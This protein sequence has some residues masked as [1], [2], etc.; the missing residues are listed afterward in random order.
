MNNLFLKSDFFRTLAKAFLFFPRADRFRIIALIVIQ[1][2]LNIL[3]LIGVAIVGIFA[4]I[5]L[6]GI[7]GLPAA[8]NIEQIFTFINLESLS[9]QMKATIIALFAGLLFL[10]KT[11]LSLY[12]SRRT[13]LF[14]S[15]KNAEAAT[16]I[17]SKLLNQDLNDFQKRTQQENI[18]YIGSGINMITTG[19][20]STTISILADISSLLFMLFGLLFL[21]PVV[22]VVTL[23]MFG[24]I[25]LSLYF[26]M[27]KSAFI[28]GKNQTDL[29]IQINQKTIEVFNSYREAFVR[30]RRRF[31]VNE[32]KKLRMLAAKDRAR[33]DFLPG[34]SRY[35]IEFTL[36][37]SIITVAGILFIS[38]D[39]GGAVA[40]LSVFAAASMRISPA[41]L[42]LQQSAVSI[43]S[44]IGSSAGILDLL[45][46]LHNI[47]PLEDEET[48]F[49]EEHSDFFPRVSIENIKFKYSSESDFEIITRSLHFGPNEIVVLAGKSG[50]GK[51][52]FADL[53]LGLM[54]VNSGKVLISNENPEVALKRW[55]GAIAYVPQEIMIS[56]GSI[57]ENVALGFP[58]RMSFD[59]EIWQALDSAQLIDFV[60]SLKNGL[61]EQIGDSGGK[62]S[63]G[64][65]QRLGIARALFTKPKLIVLDEPTSA[66]DRD[67][68][69]SFHEVLKK[70]KKNSTIILIAHTASSIE[71]ADQVIHFDNGRVEKRN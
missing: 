46:D 3:D 20:I 51:S 4:S 21:Q 2:F 36:V 70:L 45:N 71:I 41:V 9:I 30:N 34:L 61:D 1:V 49:V 33:L 44:T 57:R 40:G 58:E 10:I 39:A 62:L 66:L 53:I 37:L 68:T 24:S 56:N 52:T 38:R 13:I 48:V 29:S 63:G 35:V 31:Y 23:F 8:S 28:L 19:V 26:Y 14:L 12:L 27:R 15:N 67:T 43:R 50:S 32:I 22:A 18:Y 5:A 69:E 55:P 65:K 60:K 54:K 11:L 59:E 42:R 7:K 16:R 25:S 64:Q 17:T 6:N 47:D